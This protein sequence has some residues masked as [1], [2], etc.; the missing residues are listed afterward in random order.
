MRLGRNGGGD[1]AQPPGGVISRCP[2]YADP[3]GG[4]LVGCQ[5]GGS[6]RRAHGVLDGMGGGF[7]ADE[8][9]ICGR[10]FALPA[11]R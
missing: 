5:S 10:A 2:C 6:E 3:D 9:R 4:D 7:D 8:A 11:D 1:V